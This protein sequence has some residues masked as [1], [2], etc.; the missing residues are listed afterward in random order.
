MRIFVT[1][2]KR[3][4]KKE[5]AAI[6]GYAAHDSPC[7]GFNSD[8]W[9]CYVMNIHSIHTSGSTPLLGVT[10]TVQTEPELYLKI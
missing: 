4:K 2:G 8:L 7:F 9:P 10:D 3:R 6:F 1:A 5:K